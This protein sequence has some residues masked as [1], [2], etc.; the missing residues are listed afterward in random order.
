MSPPDSDLTQP[1]R[2]PTV[3]ELRRNLAE[4]KRVVMAQPLDLDARI[5]IA[6]TLRLLKRDEESVE[7]YRSVLKYLAQIGYAHLAIGVAQELLQ[8]APDHQ[9]TMLLLAKL[10]AQTRT[11]AVS[12]ATPRTDDAEHRR[13]GLL[14][15]WPRSATGL[16][17]AIQPDPSRSLVQAMAT[18]T[19]IRQDAGKSTF[20]ALLKGGLVSPPQSAPGQPVDESDVVAEAPP[21]PL[22]SSDLGSAAAADEV[23]DA[24]D[25]GAQAL[26]DTPVTTGMV[27]DSLASAPATPRPPTME[28][29]DEEPVASLESVGAVEMSTTD[30][31]A[32][33]GEQ[34]VLSVDSAGAEESPETTPESDPD[35]LDDGDASLELGAIPPLPSGGEEVPTDPDT[36]AVPRHA[37]TQ[38]HGDADDP[39]E[40]VPSEDDVL[41]E[42]DSDGEHQVVD[43][44]LVEEELPHPDGGAIPALRTHESFTLPEI[45]LLDGLGDGGRRI[46]A[47]AMV[48]RS[49]AAGTSLWKPGD[50]ASFLVILVSGEAVAVRGEEGRTVEL[51]RLRAGDVAGVSALIGSRK[52]MASL[53]ALTDVSYLEL[54]RSV[55]ERLMRQTPSLGAAIKDFVRER[56]VSNILGMLPVL[57]ALPLEERTALAGRFKAKHYIYGDEL[58]YE[59]AD[60][61]G[62]WVILEGQ[63]SVG[64]ESKSGDV[65]ATVT[66]GPGQFVATVAALKGKTTDLC[67]VASGTVTTVTL[68]HRTLLDMAEEHPALRD[69]MDHLPDPAWK[70]G[71]HVLGG[72]AAVPSDQAVASPG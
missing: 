10:Y 20:S 70:L 1:L 21:P 61:C 12:I 40:L 14:G 13:A 9:E 26:L 39:D 2:P 19:T 25:V 38:D 69:L 30:G 37:R 28:E 31:L 71:A 67:A 41:S 66:L 5:R 43:E 51:A 11:G 3:R 46:L 15:A 32:T 53:R 18:P 65:D 34:P 62:L 64:H 44:S 45:P 4:L 22:P 49:A 6:R 52:R 24:A 16:W 33:T 47:Q 8:V 23:L 36:H 59:N 35:P 50:D 27:E 60:V 63:V 56:L 72:H 48:A 7:H 42:E 58:F 55:A 54:Q 57:S 17:R 68:S 29:L